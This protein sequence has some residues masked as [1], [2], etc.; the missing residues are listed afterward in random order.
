MKKIFKFKVV[1]TLTAL[2]VLAVSCTIGDP[3]YVESK[4]LGLACFLG[5]FVS[6]LCLTV[7]LTLE[8]CLTQSHRSCK[9]KLLGIISSWIL[10]L[11]IYFNK[12]R[13]LN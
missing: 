12:K 6:L 1:L 13:F 8:N 3:L 7:L 5:L 11:K 9:S 10:F 2:L 4:R